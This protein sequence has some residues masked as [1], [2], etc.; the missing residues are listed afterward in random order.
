MALSARERRIITTI[1]QELA[2]YDPQWTQRFI[3]G[4]RRFARL[5]HRM[6]HR[7]RRR[8]LGSCLALVWT[9]LLCAACVHGPGPWLWAGLVATWAAAVLAFARFWVRRHRYGNG[10]GG[11]W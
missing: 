7:V 9:A 5:E 10:R 8:I 2:D 4:H 1:E 6:L 11:R 3:R